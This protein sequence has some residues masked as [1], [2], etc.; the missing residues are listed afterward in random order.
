MCLDLEQLVEIS[1]Q[2]T[3]KIKIW[4]WKISPNLNEGLNSAD[5][6]NR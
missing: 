6:E 2:G 5:L 3:I 1:N 4:S